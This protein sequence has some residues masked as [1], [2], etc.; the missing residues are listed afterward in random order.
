MK[1]QI[2]LKYKTKNCEDFNQLYKVYKYIFDEIFEI[3]NLKQKNERR[4][5][6]CEALV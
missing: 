2:I 4:I 5:Q 3:I 1:K 6:N